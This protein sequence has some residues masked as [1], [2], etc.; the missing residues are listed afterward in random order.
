MHIH[1]HAAATVTSKKTIPQRI[2]RMNM[3]F[4]RYYHFLLG[5][6]VEFEKATNVK[7]DHL[8]A[9]RTS[10]KSFESLM[11]DKAWHARIT[12]TNNDDKEMIEEIRDVYL[13]AFIRYVY[14]IYMNIY[15][16]YTYMHMI[17]YIYI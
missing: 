13:P 15:S 16:M 4:S 5:K 11:N 7:P 8:A 14:I 2:E 3:I 12:E 10:A 1:I 17:I 9:L 6:I